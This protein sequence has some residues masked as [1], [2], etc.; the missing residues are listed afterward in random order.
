MA[1]MHSIDNN[2]A[3]PKKPIDISVIF[4][5]KGKNNM[6]TKNALLYQDILR[7]GRE[8]K[9][10]EDASFRYTDLANWLMKYNQEFQDYYSDSYKKTPPNVKIANNRQRIEGLIE[11]LIRLGL[12][13]VK[14]VIQAE[15]IKNQLNYMILQ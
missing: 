3:W 8:K 13:K 1:E 4:E 12:L 15:K 6:P 14:S 9:Y 2:I 5:K 10:E 11:G 7:Y